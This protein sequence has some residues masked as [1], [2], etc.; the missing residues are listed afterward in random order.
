M[1]NHDLLLISPAT[2]D[3]ATTMLHFL[4]ALVSA[5][6]STT[7]AAMRVRRWLVA[8]KGSERDAGS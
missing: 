7:V 8:R 1:F 4:A 2:L 3:E 5:G 6:T